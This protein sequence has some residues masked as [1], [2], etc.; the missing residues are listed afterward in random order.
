[1]FFLASANYLTAANS[2]PKGP[3]S[4]LTYLIMVALLFRRWRAE[5]RV[6]VQQKQTDGAAIYQFQNKVSRSKSGKDMKRLPGELFA[7][8]KN[9]AKAA[10][11]HLK[12]LARVRPCLSPAIAEVLMPAVISS[13]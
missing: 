8:V 11:Y 10:F 6:T 5:H 2:L 3:L 13:R 4:A 9:A 1:M 7:R 12:N